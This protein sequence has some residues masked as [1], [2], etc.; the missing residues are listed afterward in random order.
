LLTVSRS[1]MN[2][3]NSVLW[4]MA[5]I[6]KAN[7]VN[8]LYYLFCLFS[9]TIHRTLQTHHIWNTYVKD[10]QN[11]EFMIFK[12]GG[13]IRYSEIQRLKQRFF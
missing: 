13:T 10:L 11:A 3:A 9:G 1:S 7:K 2:V 6:M 5:I 8:F 4:S 12:P